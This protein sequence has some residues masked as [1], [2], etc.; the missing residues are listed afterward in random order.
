[1]SVFLQ[2]FVLP[3]V[4]AIAVRSA[5]KKHLLALFGYLRSAAIVAA[6]RGVV[7]S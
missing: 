4:G 2:V 1:M 3:T 6:G 5:H 7:R